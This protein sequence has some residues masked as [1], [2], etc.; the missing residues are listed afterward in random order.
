MSIYSAPS[1][2]VLMASESNA[3]TQMPIANGRNSCIHSGQ[4]ETALRVARSAETC[5]T[6][7]H[8]T[9]LRKNAS[10]YAVFEETAGT[11][12]MGSTGRATSRS[13]NPST[14]NSDPGNATR[15][16]PI[17]ES[18]SEVPTAIRPPRWR[19]CAR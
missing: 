17:R 5:P 4:P 16:N 7:N 8:N 6:A 13:K 12:S 9:M 3:P 19:T 18:A 1:T 11:P 15:S 10:R 2:T 14:P